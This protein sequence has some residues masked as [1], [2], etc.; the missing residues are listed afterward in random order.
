[1]TYK[2][3]A[4]FLL[5][6]G[7][8][9]NTIKQ[10]GMLIPAL[11]GMNSILFQALNCQS[12]EGEPAQQE[13]IALT[14]LTAELYALRNTLETRLDSEQLP[15]EP[16]VITSATRNKDDTFTVVTNYSGFK[17]LTTSEAALNADI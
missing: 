10:L 8:G 2:E 12:Q 7:Q 4:T 3:L 5:S 16:V 6:K 17:L 11:V 1:M 9:Q 14:T 13:L 15:Y